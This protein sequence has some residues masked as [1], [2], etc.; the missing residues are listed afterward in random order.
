M[1]PERPDLPELALRF[2]EPRRQ[3]GEAL[4]FQVVRRRPEPIV[5]GVVQ[6]ATR[7]RRQVPREDMPTQPPRR[8]RSASA[9]A[10]AGSSMAMCATG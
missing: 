7:V 8:A 10:R 5:G 4:H 6:Q 9:T 1:M 2:R 3:R